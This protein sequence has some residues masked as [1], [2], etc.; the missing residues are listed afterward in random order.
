MSLID[1]LFLA[2][3]IVFAIFS[4][5]RG[6][7]RTIL[8]V[9]AF[10]LAIVLASFLSKPV[11]SI[12]YNSFIRSNVEN[13]IENSINEINFDNKTVSKDDGARIVFENIPEFAWNIAKGTGVREDNIIAKVKNNNFTSI[14]ATDMIIDNVVEPIVLP[15]TQAVS[16]IILSA[17]LIFLLRLF[18]KMISKENEDDGFS[19]DKLIGG[20]FGIAKGFVV[21]YVVCALLQIIYYSN[22]DT[23]QGFG[24]MLSKSEVFNFMV[25][26]NPVIEGLKNMF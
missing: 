19:T 11:G 2:I 18:A 21:V 10:V 26:N 25:N 20:I 16:F 14:Q 13:H 3:I 6:F 15:A 8:E 22:A 17:V 23:S 1:L 7:M 24:E 4:Y 5:R 12:F 9:V